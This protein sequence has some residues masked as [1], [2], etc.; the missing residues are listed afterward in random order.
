M[1]NRNICKFIVD[2]S[3]ESIKI[4]NFIF[5]SDSDTMKNVYKL[6]SHR[7]MLIK[8]GS[9]VCSFDGKEFFVQTG[10]VIFG[11]EGEALS[12]TPKEKCEYMYI[13]F[14][15]SRAESLFLRF[16]INKDSRYFSGFDG[17]IPLWHDSLSSASNI[18]IDLAS[19][20]I[21]LY[22]FS[23]LAKD[24]SSNNELI[25]R[26]VKITEEEFTDSELS[27]SSI[28]EKL[29]YNSKYLSHMFKEKMGVSYTEYLRNIRIKYAVSLLD[30][31]IDSVKNI[32]YLSGFSDP[33]YFSSVF[34][35]VVGISPKEY[36][37]S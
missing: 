36:K 9:A 33:L 37:Q 19:E 4:H 27:I 31:G 20:S 12:V 6:E 16:G 24:N 32:A 14:S 2:S 29:S 26:I 30:H 35:K 7:I 28:S 8:E 15:G 1:K 17:V 13:S 10:S 3:A 25:N 21:L 34:K 18:N 5:E 22:T 11:F 23:R